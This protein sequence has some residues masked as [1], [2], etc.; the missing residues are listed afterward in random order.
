MLVTLL[1]PTSKI[2]APMT[3]AMIGA[4]TTATMIGAQQP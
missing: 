2:A 1:D 4:T 3:G